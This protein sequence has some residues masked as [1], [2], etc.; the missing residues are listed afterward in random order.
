MLT[1]VKAIKGQCEELKQRDKA[2]NALFSTA[3]S[4]VGQPIGAFFNWLNE[5]TNIFFIECHIQHYVKDCHHAGGSQNVGYEEFS[6]LPYIVQ[7]KFECKTTF[8]DSHLR[9]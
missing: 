8:H 7:G 4:K 3:V 2:F 6:S 9:L 1:P 5:K